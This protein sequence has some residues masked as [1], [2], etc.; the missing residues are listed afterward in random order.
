MER[1]GN[2][3]CGVVTGANRGLGLAWARH[4]LAPG[5]RVVASGRHRGKA[6]MLNALARAFPG[7]LRVAPLHEAVPPA[8]RPLALELPLL[9]ESEPLDLLIN[10]AGVLRRGERDGSAQAS[11]LDCGCRTHATGPFLFTQA[12]SPR[13]AGGAGVADIAS[14]IGSIGL[15]HAFPTPHYAIAA[16]PRKTGSRPCV[17]AAW[18]CWHCIPA[19][20]VPT[21]AGSKPQDSV[22]GLLRV[23]SGLGAGDSRASMEWRG[24]T[25]SW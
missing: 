3:Q 13:L 4:L 24:Q 22:A 10:N 11:A 9:T 5:D 6:T 25:L 12:Q 20:C 7:R 14:G 17:R 21:W 19:G 1:G 16:R 18:C 2:T 15:N 8:T 23:I